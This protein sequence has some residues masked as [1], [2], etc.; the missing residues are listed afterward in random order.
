MSAIT[1]RVTQRIVTELNYG[2]QISLVAL[3]QTIKDALYELYEKTGMVKLEIS[4]I[5][6]IAGQKEYSVPDLSSESTGRIVRL[7][8]LYRL[9]YDS[10]GSEVSRA[11]ISPYLYD[12]RSTADETASLASIGLKII[13]ASASSENR[14]DGLLPVA[15]A[16]FGVDDYIPSMHLTDAEIAV[17]AKSMQTLC[18]N[19][20]KPWSD[21]RRAETAGLAF[22]D[23]ISRIK[24]KEI[25]G[26]VT[27]SLGM[28]CTSKFV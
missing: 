22:A 26:N 8:S 28:R 9:V 12:V 6:E 19:T 25:R 5:S 23:A 21:T 15:V 24:S 7:D 3:S 17:T 14:A 4:K 20:G 16:A 2:G 11:L 13:L 1:T 27:R 18:G 10:N